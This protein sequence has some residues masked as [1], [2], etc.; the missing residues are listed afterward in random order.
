MSLVRRVLAALG[1][2]SIP[3]PIIEEPT[4]INTLTGTGIC[5][6]A[7]GYGV[8]QSTVYKCNKPGIKDCREYAEFVLEIDDV[9]M[10]PEH[11]Y[12]PK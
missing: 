11:G 4:G 6:Y 7:K 5:K 3:L 8:A 9:C 1:P 10:N 2:T 12:T